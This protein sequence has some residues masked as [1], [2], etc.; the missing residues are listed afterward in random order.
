M[1]YKDEYEVARLLTDAQWNSDLEQRFGGKL[2]RSYWLSPPLIARTDPLTGRPRKQRFGGWLRPL[3]RAIAKLRHLRGTL[4]DPFGWTAE[5]RRERQ[6][7]I[8]YRADLDR[9]LLAP[10]SVSFNLLLDLARLP[11]MVRGFGPIKAAAMERY[12]EARSSL[13]NKLDEPEERVAP[14]AGR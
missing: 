3:L 1:T 4:L 5:R 2:K 9:I 7:I 11:M 14:A 6:L 10:K 12:Y 8:D 13:L